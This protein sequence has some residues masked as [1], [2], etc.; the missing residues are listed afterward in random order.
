MHVSV[1]LGFHKLATVP[2][3]RPDDCSLMVAKILELTPLYQATLLKSEPH[4][5]SS[6]LTG[7]GC[8]ATP[9]VL[10]GT[11]M[12]MS[13]GVF[14]IF[15]HF[16][17]VLDVSNGLWAFTHRFAIW[18]V[19]KSIISGEMKDLGELVVLESAGKGSRKEAMC[20]WCESEE[21]TAT[22]CLFYSD[23]VTSRGLHSWQTYS[24]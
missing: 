16:P 21:Q 11:E 15:S 17:C 9:W 20:C 13:H 22:V 23:K 10:F 3:N 4:K 19:S 6:T 18:T 14:I 7:L 2:P 5:E 1:D 24:P 12:D 8:G